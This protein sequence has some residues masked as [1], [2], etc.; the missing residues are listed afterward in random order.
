MSE[1]SVGL[2]PDAASQ[3]L[4]K[5]PETDPHCKQLCAAIVQPYLQASLLPRT[6][7]HEDR[8]MSS[9]WPCMVYK[10]RPDAER[11]SCHWGQLK[12]FESELKCFTDFGLAVAG[13]DCASPARSPEPNSSKP[14]TDKGPGVSCDGQEATDLD[15]MPLILYVGA[16]P[17]RHIPAMARRFPACRFE[18]Y[19]PAN[20]DQRLRDFAAS[21]E[22]GG[23][24]TIVQDFFDDTTVQRIRDR[25]SIAPIIF[26]CDI[27]TADPQ[28]MGSE[29]VEEFIE[30]DMARQRAWVEALQPDLS[31]LKFRLPWGPGESRYLSGKVLVQAFPP[32]TSTETRL[33]VSRKDL[34]QAD[35]KYDQEV[36]EQQLMFHNTVKR[37][38][39]HCHGVPSSGPGAVV[40]L[41][42][43][44]DCAAL[45]AT[46][47]SYLGVRRGIPPHSV[48][49]QAV[50][51]EISAI[52]AEITESGRT[53]ATQYHVSSSRHGGRQFAKRRYVDATGQDCFSVEAGSA[54]VEGQ[55]KKRSRRGRRVAERDDSKAAVPDVVQK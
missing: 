37:A 29:E 20:F 26:V 17:G 44:F 51:E 42:R 43:C 18:L 12:L 31:L 24:V 55:S 47:R 28:Q 22:T 27:R 15:K 34:D 6:L 9:S 46:V 21:A 38:Q 4:A 35:T 40:G 53:L 32:C 3:S 8:F 30:R 14:T 49:N 1:V 54:V 33:V 25:K 50:G 39:L 23:R 16:A 11:S 41:D 5:L 52:I 19:D 7:Q 36:Y 10:R 13:A 48:S 45:A 2:E